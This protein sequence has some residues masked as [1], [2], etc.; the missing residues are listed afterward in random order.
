MLIHLTDIDECVES[1]LSG[2]PACPMGQICQNTVGGFTCECPVGTMRNS[3]DEC[4]R[5]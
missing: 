3:Q 2:S 4:E 1:A 5:M